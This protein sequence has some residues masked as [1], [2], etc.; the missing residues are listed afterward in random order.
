[1]LLDS[2]FSTGA[3]DLIVRVV[4]SLAVLPVGTAGSLR[5]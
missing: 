2:D 4:E 1:M 5:E 3:D